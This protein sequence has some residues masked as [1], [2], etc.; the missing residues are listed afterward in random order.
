LKKAL[1]RAN[2][3][4]TAK[5]LAPKVKEMKEKVEEMATF[6]EGREKFLDKIDSDLSATGANVDLPTIR[7]K[8]KKLNLT[9]IATQASNV[10]NVVYATYNLGKQIKDAAT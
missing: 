10:G 8:I 1:L 6:L 7:D 9:T 3:V 2:D 5:K 4:E